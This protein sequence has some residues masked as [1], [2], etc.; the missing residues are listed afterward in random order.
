MII[1]QAKT[2]SKKTHIVFRLD[3][4][5]FQAPIIAVSLKP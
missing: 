1:K 4:S 2:A 5:H 3:F